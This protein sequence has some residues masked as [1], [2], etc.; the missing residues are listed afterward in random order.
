VRQP[1]D[2][3]VVWIRDA[4]DEAIAVDATERRRRVEQFTR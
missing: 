4:G 1:I 3:A 2:Q